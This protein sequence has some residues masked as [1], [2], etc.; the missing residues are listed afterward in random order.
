[1]PRGASLSPECKGGRD[2]KQDQEIRAQSWHLPLSPWEFCF[3]LRRDGLFN[4]YEES[5]MDDSG[6]RCISNV[7]IGERTCTIPCTH[8][9]L[10][11]TRLL[12]C[13]WVHH[14]IDV[15]MLPCVRP[16]PGPVENDVSALAF[17]DSYIY[18]HKIYAHLPAHLPMHICVRCVR[19]LTP[20]RKRP[21]PAY[22]QPSPLQ[23]SP[24]SK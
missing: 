21:T 2:R 14:S 3:Q 13:A 15:P 6:W 7:A 16:M 17:S 18:P 11:L 4:V 19:A 20:T 10:Q 8:S 22:R 12:S 1:M 23:Q 5:P 9:L 24:N